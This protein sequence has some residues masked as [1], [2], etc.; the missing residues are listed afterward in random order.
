MADNY[1]RIESHSPFTQEFIYIDVEPYK[2]D[3]A[4]NELGVRP[5]FYEEFDVVDQPYVIIRC[6]V[7][8][9]DVHLFVKAMDKLKQKM[10]L[11]GYPDYED[12]CEGLWNSIEEEEK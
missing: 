5:K 12:F 10:L 6:K 8:R 1:I 7:P 9:R 2:A 3:D 11:T 4:F